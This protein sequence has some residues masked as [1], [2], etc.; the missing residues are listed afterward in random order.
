MVM[1]T[2]GCVPHRLSETSYGC[3]N[4]LWLAQALQSSLITLDM[5]WVPL[6]RSESPLR[7]SAAQRH[8]KTPMQFPTPHYAKMCHANVRQCFVI[9]NAKNLHAKLFLWSQMCAYAKNIH[10][11]NIRNLP[12]KLL[13]VTVAFCDH[14]CGKGFKNVLRRSKLLRKCA[15]AF[16]NNKKSV[17][18][19]LF[20]WK[21]IKNSWLPL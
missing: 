18:R 20:L 15:E 12:C 4:A 9:T 11:K 2:I 16:K 5:L 14:K 1:H 17:L 6:R 3:A 21:M 13:G 8:A 19:Q 10:A 7:R